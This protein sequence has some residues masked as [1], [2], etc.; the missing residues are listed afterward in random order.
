VAR[1]FRARGPVA[2]RAGAISIGLGSTLLV[3]GAIAG[4][5]GC[6][7][8]TT[9]HAIPTVTFG[10]VPADSSAATS[11]SIPVRSTPASNAATSTV[12][13]ARSPLPAAGGRL[14]IRRLGVDA[15]IVA[16]G[17]PNR[18]LDIP[19]DPHTV[20][21]WDGGAVPGSGHGSIVIAG[22]I[23]YAGVTGALA[24][25][26]DLKLGD[27]VTLSRPGHILTYSV[28]AVRTYDKSQGLPAAAF[29]QTTPEQLVLITCGGP[30]DASTGNYEDNIVAYA[31][32][33]AV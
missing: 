1:R 8:R 2:R 20:G 9:G 17:A 16:V 22:H 24:I 12:P 25:L 18:V 4:L 5:G 21:W 23:N 7:A 26:P 33:A 29:S 19:L 32:P 28:R 6:Q 10:S 13:T 14:A 27:S 30:F 11:P 15:P 3:L 31:V